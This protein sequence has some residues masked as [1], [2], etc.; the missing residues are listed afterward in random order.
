MQT[1]DPERPTLA[2]NSSIF[3]EIVRVISDLGILSRS[4]N[5]GD[6]V[7]GGATVTLVL[8]GTIGLFA[9]NKQHLAG[10]AGPGEVIGLEALAGVRL[11][12]EGRWLTPGRLLK[13]SAPALLSD[14]G[15][16]RQLRWLAETS[17][18]RQRALARGVACN[19]GHALIARLA[20]LLS[21]LTDNGNLTSLPITQQEL[22]QL[23]GVQRTSICAATEKLKKLGISRVMRGQIAVRDPDRMRAMACGC[24]SQEAFEG[25]EHSGWFAPGLRYGEDGKRAPA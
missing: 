9:P 15:D 2:S 13:V 20:N 14:D 12:L 1:R 3:D 7:A 5:Q 19:L 17:A 25:Q 23:L 16:D 6:T 4:V 10:L 22:A 8:T 18:A 11:P 24:R 21:V